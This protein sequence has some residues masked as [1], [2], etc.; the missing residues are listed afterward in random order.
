MLES[1]DLVYPQQ[2][3]NYTGFQTYVSLRKWTGGTPNGSLRLE[4]NIQNTC[5]KWKKTGLGLVIF[6]KR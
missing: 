5:I 3:K 2:G 6:F 4:T 1:N